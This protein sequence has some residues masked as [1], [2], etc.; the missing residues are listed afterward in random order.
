MKDKGYRTTQWSTALREQVHRAPRTGLESLGLLKIYLSF[1]L[2]FFL[3]VLSFFLFILFFFSF[4]F[5]FHSFFLLHSFFYRMAGGW[6]G[7]LWV[8]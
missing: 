1:F 6:R 3:F 7:R 5:S 2:T 8:V 4:F